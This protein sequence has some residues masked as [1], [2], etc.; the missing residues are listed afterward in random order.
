MSFHA[1]KVLYGHAEGLRFKS[2]EEYT[3]HLRHQYDVELFIS[4]VQ[5]DDVAPDYNIFF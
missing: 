2:V 1:A 3:P 5:H 4:M